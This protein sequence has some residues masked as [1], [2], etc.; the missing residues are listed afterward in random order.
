M[1]SLIILTLFPNCLTPVDTTP[2]K[3]KFYRVRVVDM[4][5]KKFSG[6]LISMNDS[7]INILYE[8]PWFNLKKTMKEFSYGNIRLIRVRKK[9]SI[10]D[11]IAYGGIAGAVAGAFYG[12]SVN[13]WPVLDEI[14]GALVGA[15]VG[16]PIGLIIGALQ[17][18]NYSIN[19]SKEK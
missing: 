8:A 14:F 16:M 13:E 11:G 18:K 10:A 15:L 2:V 1:K 17:I 12:L 19:G 4:S 5:G 7:S 9:E 3:A 6:D